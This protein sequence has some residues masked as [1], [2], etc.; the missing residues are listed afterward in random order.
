MDTSLKEQ[1]PRRPVD[2]LRPPPSR[3]KTAA[4][5]AN[6]PHGAGG[7]VHD[8]LRSPKPQPANMKGAEPK[9]RWPSTASEGSANSVLDADAMSDASERPFSG[10]IG[11][12][13]CPVA[14]LS[15]VRL[16]VTGVIP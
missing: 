15:L 1:M 9:G 12:V 6:S 4:L 2:I 14:E 10:K 11:Q 5:F 7:G 13:G 8:F 16:Q 3:G